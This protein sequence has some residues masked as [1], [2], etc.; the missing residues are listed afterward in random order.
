MVLLLLELCS[1]LSV[2]LL[3][4]ALFAVGFTLE[5]LQFG[6][7]L[8]NGLVF[9]IDLFLQGPRN[10]EHVLIVLVDG[11]SGLVDIATSTAVSV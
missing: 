2:L 5:L 11:L 1:Q 3:E 8:L 6:T 4:H 7:V 9:L 10:L